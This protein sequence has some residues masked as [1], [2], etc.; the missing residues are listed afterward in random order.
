MNSTEL[1]V[2]E[3]ALSAFDKISNPLEAAEKMGQ[4]FAKSKMFGV[5][6]PEQGCVLAFT[7]L[8]EK[9]NPIEF[10]RTYHLLTDGKLQMRADAMLAE[11]NKRGGTHEWIKTGEDGE[12]ILRLTKNGASIDSKYSM[13][14]AKTAN[15]IKPNSGW[16]KNPAN[17]LRAR[18]ISNGVRMIDPA[19]CAGAYTPEENEDQNEE[20]TTPDKKKPEFTKPA[21][22]KPEQK[23]AQQ[24]PPNTPTIEK[25][26]LGVF[27][28]K[29]REE[30]GKNM[31]VIT[32][33]D[34]QGE[35]K[36]SD[37]GL[38]KKVSD[39]VLTASAITVSFMK[40]PK[41]M[42]LLNIERAA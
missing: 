26:T 41:G 36:T 40:L 15:L 24:K 5:A 16:I 38:G 28:Y 2:K 14:E 37:E 9:K 29:T 27:E 13:E 3:N 34:F 30:D 18:S 42:K 1:T 11:F 6:T 22:R 33:P 32:S 7:C 19:V 10:M 12:A 21:D 39:I 8:V 31:H 35:F 23:P 20:N 4:W 17:M 25:T